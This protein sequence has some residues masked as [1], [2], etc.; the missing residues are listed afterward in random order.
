[1][2]STRT[3]IPRYFGNTRQHQQTLLHKSVEDKIKNMMFKQL[4][5]IGLRM[6]I[7]TC[8]WPKK[9]SLDL[10]EKAHSTHAFAEYLLQ[11][12]EDS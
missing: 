7:T 6:N 1:M 5:R 10:Y 11:G 12:F 8:G 3:C 9:A 4:K 2:E